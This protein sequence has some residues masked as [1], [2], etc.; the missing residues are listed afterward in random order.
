[1]CA[2]KSTRTPWNLYSQVC[3]CFL[4]MTFTSARFL[5]SCF[6]FYF[7]TRSSAWW[8]GRQFSREKIRLSCWRMWKIS[9]KW[10]RCSELNILVDQFLPWRRF[11]E[12]LSLT[13]TA[14][15]YLSFICHYCRV[16]SFSTAETEWKGFARQTQEVEG[17]VGPS[18]EALCRFLTHDISLQNFPLVLKVVLISNLDPKKT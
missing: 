13:N 8:F 14:I 1:M 2:P 15:I 11:R 7:R 12:I 10:V 17:N 5:E 16:W 6:W 18:C 9:T 3:L 4:L